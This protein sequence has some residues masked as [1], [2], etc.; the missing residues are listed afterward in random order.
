MTME[1]L[2]LLK[3]DVERNS[4]SSKRNNLP[5]LFKERLLIQALL[6]MQRI[7]SQSN[8]GHP[9]WLYL[10]SFLEYAAFMLEKVGVK[11]FSTYIFIFEQLNGFDPKLLS[12][13]SLEIFTSTVSSTLPYSLEMYNPAQEEEPGSDNPARV[14]LVLDILLALTKFITTISEFFPNPA[15]ISSVR[16]DFH[17][18]N[19]AD[20]VYRL[21]CLLVDIS[22]QITDQE[23][24]QLEEQFSYFIRN[25]FPERTTT[26]LHVAA[27]KVKNRSDLFKIVDDL[28]DI[29]ILVK[30]KPI[31]A[32]IKLILQL[33]AD[34]NAIDR[35]GRNPL[36]ILAANPDSIDEIAQTPLHI[37]AGIK[38]HH[39]NEYLPVF[40]TLVDAG[41]HLYLADDDGE[42][43]SS[44]LKEIVERD[45]NSDEIRGHHYFES[46]INDVF[47]LT[48][49][50]ARVIRRHEIPFKDRL[51]LALQKLVSL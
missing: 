46:L 37:L 23:K 44:L 26:V 33:G 5:L 15:M 24:H 42:T 43:V 38:E 16:F 41:S 36:H 20:I 45:Q 7:F 9:H 2:K 10:E 17:I 30:L 18:S 11:N 14:K 31:H 3:E 25:F 8:L 27:M 21:L 19:F 29:M 40:Q 4:S 28:N 22:S 6:V 39:L 34:P 51:P 50:C 13:R 49:F 47:P 1:E 48:W 35:M 32:Q 12:H